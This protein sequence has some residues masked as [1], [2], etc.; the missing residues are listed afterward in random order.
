MT[1]RITAPASGIRA[2]LDSLSRDALA[3]RLELALEGARLGI[4]DWDLRDDSVQFDRRWCEMLG[5]RHE[6]VRQSLE[7]WSSRVHPDDIDGCYRDIQAHIAGE[8]DYYENVHRMRHADGTWRYILDRGRVSGHDDDGKP[9]R[10]TGTHLDVTAFEEAKRALADKRAQ[11][12]QLVRYLPTPVAMLDRE[13]K[14]IEASG[15]WLVEFGVGG[16]DWRGRACT[17]VL[18][19]YDAVLGDALRHALDGRPSHCDEQPVTDGDGVTTWLRWRVHPWRTAAGAIGGVTVHL[20][21]IT[22]DVE[23]R[24]KAIAE[25][26]LAALGIMAGGIAHE[27]NSPLHVMMIE[28]GFIR[29]ELDRTPVDVDEIR[30]SLAT[31]DDALRQARGIVRSMRALLR[32]GRHGDVPTCME[33][34]ALFADIASLCSAMARALCVQFSV[35]SP[36]GLTVRGHRPQ[37]GQILVNLVV[38]ALDAVSGQEDGAV[39]LCAEEAP[40]GVLLKVLDNG[41]GISEADAERVME[42]FFT[43]KPV[44]KGTGLGLSISRT[45]AERSGAV[46]ALTRRAEPTEF[47]LSFPRVEAGA[48]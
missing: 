25:A 19:R 8:T 40:D 42:P 1:D 27:I 14:Y 10:M 11:M 2:F 23:V 22:A 35:Q 3:A 46:L 48:S 5:L 47:T 24:S 28:Q 21:D 17:Q 9:I 41:P 16:R 26:R 18:G 37:V 13:L 43:T 15:R 38:N 7:S 29:E 6:E 30:A 4:W 45:L 33:V 44:G 32:S 34:S 12:V 20:E 31:A 39:R 36:D